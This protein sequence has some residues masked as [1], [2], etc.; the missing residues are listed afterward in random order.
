MDEFNPPL[1]FFEDNF[2]SFEDESGGVRRGQIFHACPQLYN[3]HGVKISRSP[4]ANF[5]KNKSRAVL[6]FFLKN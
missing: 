6:I 4:V 5:T 2:R 3:T 1:S